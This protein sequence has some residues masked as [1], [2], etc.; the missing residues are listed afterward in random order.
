MGSKPSSTSRRPA[1]S[2]PDALA[3]DLDHDDLSRL[4]RAVNDSGVSF[5]KMADR[6]AAAGHPVSKPYMQKLATNSVGTAPNPEQLR[7]IAAAL[8]M[9]L[10]AVQRAAAAQWLDYKATE[11]S[12]YNDDVR[13]IVAHLAGMDPT[14]QKRWRRMI[15]AAESVNEDE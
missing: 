7:G 10:P 2:I 11:L 14:R 13:V 1:N 6:S 5:Q 9:P 8:Q 3:A 15:E 12:G 4:V